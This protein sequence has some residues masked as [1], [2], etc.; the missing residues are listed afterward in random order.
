MPR[1]LSL[2]AAYALAAA[3]IA[4]QYSMPILYALVA[5]HT[6]V[7]AE[8]SATSG[9]ANSVARRILESLPPSTAGGALEETRVS[10][11]Q[12]GHL[13]H[14][15]VSDG[16]TYVCMVRVRAR[17]APCAVHTPVCMRAWSCLFG[18]KEQNKHMRRFVASTGGP[19]GSHSSLL[20]RKQQRWFVVLGVN[21]FGLVM[22]PTACVRV[23]VPPGARLRRRSGG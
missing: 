20:L 17:V 13:F 16:N 3:R 11:S 2:F 5:R 22:C 9:N 14:V 21:L 8:Y 4:V 7:L 15:S 6:A 19:R 18:G 12:D 10:Y 23:W 1:H